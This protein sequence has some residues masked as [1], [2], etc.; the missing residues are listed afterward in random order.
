MQPQKSKTQKK[1]GKPSSD[2]P[3]QWLFE[4]IRQFK[5]GILRY[6]IAPN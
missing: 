2:M 1:T 3:E 6:R 4:E 5:F